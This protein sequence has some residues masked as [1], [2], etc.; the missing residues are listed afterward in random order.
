MKRSFDQIMW[1]R[2]W[3]VVGVMVLAVICIPFIKRFT[4]PTYTA[5]AEISYVGNSLN[6]VIPP[7]DLPELAMSESVLQRA[8]SMGNLGLDPAVLLLKTTVRQ[9]PHSNVI[10]VSFRSKN[11]R[12]AVA[13]AN[14]VVDAT[15]AEYHDL[16]S[17]QYDELIDKLTTQA[18]ALR[19]EV[20]VFNARYESSVRNDPM[21]GVTGGLDSLANRLDTLD[22]SRA[23][24]RA[25]LAQDTASATIASAGPTTAGL[26]DVIREET[27]AHDPAFTAISGAESK[28]L[29]DYETMKAGY[30][31]AFPGLAGLQTKVQ[32]EKS[33]VA[34][35]GKVAEKLHRGASPTYAQ[36]LVTGQAS[37]SVV[38]GD[39]A[40]V[41]ALDRDYGSLRSRLNDLPRLTGAA[42]DFRVQRDGAIAAYSQVVTRLSG[43]VGDKAQA[44]SLNSIVV[45]N[46]ATAAAPNFPP[47][48]ALGLV[49]ALIFGFAVGLAYL[50]E[51]LDPRIRTQA[52]VEALYGSPLLGS[53]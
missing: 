14:A 1:S 50:A 28:D 38:A 29:A 26:R 5:V 16:A 39:R 52:D 44:G 40:Q 45:L 31:D 21:A 30:N 46:H 10:P 22:Q 13:A 34:R 47:G 8:I 36:L 35:E 25:K 11:E 12:Q 48:V 27:V 15:V 4:Q 6:S 19:H 32:L 41:A 9:S 3:L 24:A 7:T 37:A 49:I 23:A 43:A 20:G 2:R 17:R 51:M 53:L 18:T 42:N 33:A